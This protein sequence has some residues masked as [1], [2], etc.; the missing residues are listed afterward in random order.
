LNDDM[1]MEYQMMV[2]QEEHDLVMGHY[3]LVVY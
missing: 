2:D 1:Q 3:L